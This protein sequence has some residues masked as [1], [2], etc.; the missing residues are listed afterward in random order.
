MCNITALRMLVTADQKL[1]AS[2]PLTLQ[3]VLT[4]T[5]ETTELM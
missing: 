3:V 4:R 1:N 2:G 5:E